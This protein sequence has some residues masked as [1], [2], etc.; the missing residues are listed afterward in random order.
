MGMDVMLYTLDGGTLSASHLSRH[1][2]KESA[3]ELPEEQSGWAQIPLLM[4][5]RKENILS[6]PTIET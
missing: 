3:P 5:C 2:P 6:V 4:L 1:N